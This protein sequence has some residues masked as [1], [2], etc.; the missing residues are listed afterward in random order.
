MT[1]IHLELELLRDPGW[2]SLTIRNRHIDLETCR[3]LTLALK[4]NTTLRS[5]EMLR[6]QMDF[7][8]MKLIF[9]ALYEHPSIEKFRVEN[10]T[11]VVQHTPYLADLIRRNTTL[12][13]LNVSGI[14]FCDNQTSIGEAL[15][16]NSTLQKLNLSCFIKLGRDGVESILHGLRNNTTL[17]ELD[18][19]F[20]L[21]SVP[22]EKAALLR[23]TL[24][25]N[26]H[27]Q[28]MKSQELLSLVWDRV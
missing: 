20:E 23:D 5:F 15:A 24:R 8:G 21:L 3:T 14:V 9:E 26:K 10:I 4:A 25:R 1:C 27:N 19:G 2:K 22:I 6:N 11:Y 28:M 7:D 17:V 12:R 18:L 16:H 13:K